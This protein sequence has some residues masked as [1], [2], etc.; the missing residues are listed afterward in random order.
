[1][2]IDRV[3]RDQFCSLFNALR[4]GALKSP[5]RR[6]S[7]PHYTG[8]SMP[9]RP[10]IQHKRHP[11]CSTPPRGSSVSPH[12]RHANLTDSH[13]GI[14]GGGQERLMSL[15]SASIRLNTVTIPRYTRHS[16]ADN[17]LPPFWA[18]KEYLQCCV[19]ANTSSAFPLPSRRTPSLCQLYENKLAYPSISQTLVGK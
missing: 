6:M 16:R 1:M 9:G 11:D 13:T 18:R 14:G 8:S 17:T 4:Y 12:P 7:L 5:C 2:L 3:T 19:L 15:R 10:Y